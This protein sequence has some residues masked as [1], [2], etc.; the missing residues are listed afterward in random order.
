M[1]ILLVWLQI[2]P[3]LSKTTKLATTCSGLE[4]GLCLGQIDRKIFDQFVIDKSVENLEGFNLV[5]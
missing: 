4:I 1:Q 3:A 2:N 5:D